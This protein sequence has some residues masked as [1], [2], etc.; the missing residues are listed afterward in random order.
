MSVQNRRKYDPE[1]KRNAVRLS[2]E[3]GRTVP[4]VTENLGVSSALLYRWRQQERENAELSF[5][6]NGNIALTQEQKR[7]R[8]L[9][10]KLKDTEMERD[11]LKKAMAIFSRTSK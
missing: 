10:N 9:E 8:E 1:F 2:E 5:P 6:G 4:E 3:A 11:I 7:I